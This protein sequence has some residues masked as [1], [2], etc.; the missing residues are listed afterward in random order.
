[1]NELLQDLINTG[2]VATFINDIIVETEMED[3]HNKIVAE[4]I[5]KLEENDL[6]IKLEKYKWKVREVGFLGVVIGP[7]EI[8]MEKEKVRG[9]LEWPTPKYI[10]D[11]Q[12]FLGLVNYY[13]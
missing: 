4:V 2:K 3:R 5:R 11:I 12:K 8:K 13:Y 10:K 6:Y 7:E 9:I 1:M